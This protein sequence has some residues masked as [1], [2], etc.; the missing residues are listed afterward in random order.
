M[1]QQPK[2]LRIKALKMFKASV[3][4]ATP[5]MLNPGDVVDVDLFLGSMLVNSLKAELTEEKPRIQKDYQPE[6][7]PSSVIADPLGA[8]L[9]AIEGLTKV[10][11][12][13]KALGAAR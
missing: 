4:G 7:R 8:I 3:E 2:L 12:T 13:N 5:I 10:L 1:A 11:G 6:P 9:H